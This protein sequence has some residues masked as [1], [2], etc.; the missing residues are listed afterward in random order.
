ML[1][2]GWEFR[3]DF[4]G[5]TGDRVFGAPYLRDISLRAEP[6]MTGRAIV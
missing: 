1:S 2:E 3:T 6:E 4:P 5:T